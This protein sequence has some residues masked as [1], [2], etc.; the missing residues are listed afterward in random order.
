MWDKVFESDDTANAEFE[1][2]LGDEGLDA[3]VN[4]ADETP[5]PKH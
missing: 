5:I 4:D 1:K 2:V 3:L